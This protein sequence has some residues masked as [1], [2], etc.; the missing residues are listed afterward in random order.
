[1]TLEAG[2]LIALIILTLVLGWM[3]IRKLNKLLKGQNA[4]S[5]SVS[6]VSAAADKIA[7]DVENIKRWQQKQ[8]DDKAALIAERDGLKQTVTDLQEKLAAGQLDEAALNAASEKLTAA[9][10]AL[11]EIHPDQP[12]VAPETPG[13][14]PAETPAEQPAEAPAGSTEPTPQG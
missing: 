12:P 3:V 10:K 4:M 5:E 6:K 1:M 11:D 2:L 8:S 14:A 7:E 13:E 9:D